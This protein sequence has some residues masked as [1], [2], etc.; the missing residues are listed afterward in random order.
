MSN[1]HKIIVAVLLTIFG[2][3]AVEWVA[4]MGDQPARCESV[5]FGSA[6][7][8]LVTSF[9]SACLFADKGQP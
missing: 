1:K 3:I 6:I 5:G 8:L 7:A 4:F 9:I 2:Q